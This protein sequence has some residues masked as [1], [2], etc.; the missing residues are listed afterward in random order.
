MKEQLE[1]WNTTAT[2]ADHSGLHVYGRI[3]LAGRTRNSPFS[4]DFLVRRI[5]DEGILGM[6]FLAGQKCTLCLDMGLLAWRGDAI[7]LVDKDCRAT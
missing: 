4:M 3:T 6:D 1:S 7:L 5:S 2:L